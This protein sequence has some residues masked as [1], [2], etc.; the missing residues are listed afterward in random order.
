M[1]D[2]NRT[3]QDVISQQERMLR[4]AERDYGLTLAVLRAETGI[5][6]ETLASWKRDVAMPAWALVALSRAIPDELVSL[7]FEPAEKVVSSIETGDEVLDELAE[8]AAE[9]VAEYTRARSPNSPGG[10]QIIPRERAKLSETA[11][12]VGAKARLVK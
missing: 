8:E 4:L 1:S 2:A 10:A 9:Y 6:K 7:M 12:R 5:P 11:R 3:K